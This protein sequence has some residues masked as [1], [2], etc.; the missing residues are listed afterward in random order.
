MYLSLS[1]KNN[2]MSRN[3]YIDNFILKE[4]YDS[5]YFYLL[6]NS[7]SY[8]IYAIRIKMA[9]ENKYVIKIGKT[10]DIKKRINSLMDEF[11]C[12]D[13]EIILLF[14]GKSNYIQAESHIH[15]LLKQKYKCGGIKD[16]HGR[17]SYEVYDISSNLYDD[18]TLLFSQVTRNNYF[19]SQNYII[20][21]NNIEH[22]ILSNHIIDYFVTSN[23]DI[24]KGKKCCLLGG[25]MNK[26]EQEFWKIIKNK[27][28]DDYKD[29]D[30]N[31]E[32]D[33]KFYEYSSD[34][35][36]EYSPM[37]IDTESNV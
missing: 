17:K 25:Y 9:H 8:G 34:E 23:L 13:G 1:N 4:I 37:D 31:V 24:L 21:D 3:N 26:Y 20:N 29:M 28:L 16:H 15:Q 22:Y 33:D 11:N 14:F 35:F 27:F 30:M 2:I 6:E 32:M 18:I 36:T 10:L 5:P 7:N 12:C 19:E